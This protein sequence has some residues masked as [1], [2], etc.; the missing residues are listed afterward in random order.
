MS[1]SLLASLPDTVDASSSIKAARAFGVLAALSGGIMSMWMLISIVFTGTS[2]PSWI[3]IASLLTAST[4]FQLLTF[5]AFNDENCKDDPENETWT[6][7]SIAEGSSYAISASIFYLLSSFGTFLVYPPQVPLV[8]FSDDW[9]GNEVNET[10]DIVANVSDTRPAHTAVMLHQEEIVRPGVS[11]TVP[12]PPMEQAPYTNNLMQ[13]GASFP[14]PE[15]DRSG[16]LSSTDP[17]G[18]DKFGVEL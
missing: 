18:Q 1:Y 15:D 14:P 13:A 9:R 8:Q 17:N 2:K 12:P 7:C 6:K 3:T 10:S 11:S 16:T 5:L 4:A